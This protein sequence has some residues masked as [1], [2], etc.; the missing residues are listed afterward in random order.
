MPS[1]TKE[2]LK[3]ITERFNLENHN[4]KKFVETGT[5]YANTIQ[6]LIDEFEEIHSIELSIPFY[7]RAKTIFEKNNKVKLYQGDSMYVLPEVLKKINESCIFFLDGHY[8]SEDTAKGEKEVPLLEELESIM[9]EFNNEC[10]IIIDDLRLF[11]TTHSEDW[12]SVSEDA[13]IKLVEPRME[14]YEKINDRF[15]VKLKK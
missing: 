13:V 2:N 5:H 8:S 9:T 14:K 12:G 4:Y 11:G 3:E 1:L 7:N 15:I 6:H 10:L